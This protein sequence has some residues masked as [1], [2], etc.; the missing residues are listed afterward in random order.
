M[1]SKEQTAEMSYL[2][3]VVGVTP[4]SSPW[5]Y[6]YGNFTVQE[7]TIL[8]NFPSAAKR[9]FAIE[10]FYQYYCD[11]KIKVFYGYLQDYGTTQPMLRNCS[12]FQ[13]QILFD[14]IVMT[15]N[16]KK[17]YHITL[18]CSVSCVTFLVLSNWFS[19]WRQIWGFSPD[20]GFQCL[21]GFFFWRS[22]YFRI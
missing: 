22:V 4:K 15:G 21:S 16:L 9:N 6:I 2:R 3:R 1:L 7:V 13:I 18:T 17:Y 19:Q 8:L 5:L 20:L 14:G 12:N 10:C 11:L